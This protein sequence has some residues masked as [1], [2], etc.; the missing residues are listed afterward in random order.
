MLVKVPLQ[1]EWKEQLNQMIV[2]SVEPSAKKSSED[3][4]SKKLEAANLVSEATITPVKDGA[5]LLPVPQAGRVTEILGTPTRES[6][7]VSSPVFTK[8]KGRNVKN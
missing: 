4:F 5:G 3:D 7:D 1:R 6:S 8:A 2:E